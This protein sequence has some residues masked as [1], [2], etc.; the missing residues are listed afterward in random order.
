MSDEEERNKIE[1]FDSFLPRRS[2]I[3]LKR[4]ILDEDFL[5]KEKNIVRVNSKKI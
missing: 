1:F 5:K 4:E 3:F 2:L